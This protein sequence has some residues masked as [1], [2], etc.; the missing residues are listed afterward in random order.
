MPLHFSNKTALGY[1][2]II[3]RQFEKLKGYF[4]FEPGDIFVEV[5]P[6]DK[7]DSF[8]EFSRGCKPLKFTVGSALDNGGILILDKKDF[9]KKQGHFP[10]EFDE[11]VLHEMAHIFVRRITWPKHAFIWIQE[12]VCEYLSFGHKKFEIKKPVDFNNIEDEGGWDRYNP[13]Q[14]AGAF[15]KF[16]SEKFGDKKIVEFI[17]NIKESQKSQ[18]RLFEGVF[19][20]KFEEIERDF[21]EGHK[22]ENSSSF[23]ISVRN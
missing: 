2:E 12:G 14:Q 23:G 6:L 5:L 19:S 17:K 15:F 13:Y 10:E 3:F 20:V 16:L 21:F 11:V 9:S 8:Y 7:F 4:D 1:K 22:N 18:Y